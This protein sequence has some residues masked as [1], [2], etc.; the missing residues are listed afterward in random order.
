MANISISQPVVSVNWLYAN[1]QA[2]N[3]VILNATLPKATITNVTNKEEIQIPN[4]IFFDIKNKFSDTTSDFP[5][6]FPS[7]SQFKKEVQEIGIHNHSAIVIYDEQGIYSSARAWY[8][9]KAFGCQNVAVLNGGFPEWK[10]N[11]FPTQKKQ[12]KPITKGNF[13]VSKQENAILFFS[14]IIKI[15]DNKNYTILDARASNRFQGLVPEPRAELPRGNIT[16][17]K[18]LPFQ[19]L[20]NQ[21]KLKPKKELKTI[22]KSITN[23]EEN[24]VFSCGSGITACI[25]ALAAAQLDYKNYAVYDGSW[26]EYANLISKKNTMKWTKN[27]LVAYTLLYAANSNMEE[28]NK[29]RNKIIEHV[30]M[31]TF[32]KIHDEFDAD[33]DY[34]SIQKIQEG[35]KAHHYT[36]NDIED[37][38][39][40]VQEMF[41]ADG[42]FDVMERNLFRS[43]KKILS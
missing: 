4:A 36:K 35:L 10:K 14:E 43:L 5:N 25:L 33:N 7:A 26:T 28:D 31:Q 9:F 41:F 8:L 6:T 23:K 12:T 32:Q 22:F 34:Q 29:E 18:N 38:L 11:K 13:T 19:N 2:P 16:N 27:E 15:Q 30:D 37:L 3:L 17:S 1:L 42:K 39:K 24:L 21:N 20:L 40:E